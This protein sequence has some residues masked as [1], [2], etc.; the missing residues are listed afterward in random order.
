[1]NERDIV[2]I[3]ASRG[4]FE[5]LKNLAGQLPADLPAA[6]FVVLHIGRHGSV[7]PDLMT[8]WGPL[9]ARY[10]AHGEAIR[11]GAILVAPPDRHLVLSDGCVWLNDGAKENY[12]RPAADPL[13]RS[14]AEQF[15]RRVV[16]VVL[17]GDLDDGAAGLAAIRA[18]GGFGIVQSPDDCESAA[19]PCA[20][21]GAAGADAVCT[22]AQLAQCIQRAL[23]GGPDDTAYARTPGV[24]SVG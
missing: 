21:L 2:V 16:G 5:V 24:I 18:R 9:T 3:A 8:G 7:L 6:V 17:S 14:A 11:R 20:A 13:F 22:E 10:A 12:A 4:G 1:M 19:M 15:G 23:R